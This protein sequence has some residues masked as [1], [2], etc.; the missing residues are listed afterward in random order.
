MTYVEELNKLPGYW[1]KIIKKLE[2]IQLKLTKAKWSTQFNYVCLQENLLPNYTRMRHHDPALASSRDTMN[3]RKS[4]VQRELRIKRETAL[5]IERE[6][7][8]QLTYINNSDIN[9]GNALRE[10]K[11]KMDNFNNV[12]KAKT[13]KKLNQLYNGQIFL[14]E[15]TNCYVNLSQYELT[16]NE[17]EFLNLGINFH[18]QPKYDRLTKKTELELLYNNLVNLGNKN[19]I[20]I[21]QDLQEQL[22]SEGTKHRNRYNR[23]QLPTHLKDAAKK[24]R[25]NKDIIIRKADKS[26]IYVILDRDD[27]F[28]KLNS[29]LSDTTKFKVINKD[30]TNELKVKANKLIDSLNSVQDDIKIDKIVGDFDPGYA[31][32]N[33]KIHKHGNPLR[34]II[35]QCP[36]PTYQLAKTINKII[37]PYIPNKFS[38]K[39]PSDFI[40]ILHSTTTNGII[41][42]L[43]VDS[44]FTNVPIDPTIDIIIKYVY[45]HPILPPPK[46]PQNI[47]R[48]FL[49]ICTK[50][51]PF[52]SPTGTLY[53][54]IEGV[55][56]GSPLGPT[57]AGFYMGDLEYNVFNNY[58]TKPNIYV[59][60]V[61]DIFLQI[62]NSDQLTDIKDI[63]QQ[64]SVLTFTYELHVNN[65]LPFLDISVTSTNTGFKTSIHYK[66]TD[67]GRC[68][69]AQG[70]CPDKY[71]LSVINN[72]IHRAYK[73]S[74]TWESFHNEIIHIK[75]TLINNNYSNSMVDNEISRYLNNKFS[76]PNHTDHNS[77]PVYY[78]SQMHSNYKIDEK[79]LKDIVYNNI[80][81]INPTDK[82][83]LIIYYNNRKASNLVLKNNLAPPKT[84]L[85][86]TNLVYAFICPL[87]HPKVSV[88]IGYTKTRLLRRLKSHLQK[89]SIKEHFRLSHN[90]ELTND[91]VCNNT[92]IIAKDSDKYRLT[93]KEA[94]LI[95]Q[96]GPLINKQFDNFSNTLKLFKNNTSIEPTI[97]SFIHTNTPPIRNDCTHPPRSPSP[98]QDLNISNNESYLNDHITNTHSISPNINNRIHSLLQNSRNN[99]N[100]S[101]QP[102]LRMRSP[103]LLRPRRQRLSYTSQVS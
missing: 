86:N 60:Y 50:E 92:H 44:L 66:P 46:I 28:N 87:T 99:I 53:L 88:Y 32:G 96:H 103:H 56:M 45:H 52:R 84:S 102:S 91:I 95:S 97:P 78:K 43:D 72:F 58:Y 81:C 42:S 18:L 39:S 2:N 57:F 36:T 47:M 59:R 15:E 6:E 40:D 63:F 13:L 11:I 98:T 33:V 54:Q 20:T 14:K 80:K 62:N 27:Y 64:K 74:Q 38:I 17:K 89:G 41:A 8:D 21:N 82:L 22:A 9:C 34:P 69:N 5:R 1:K 71:K 94:L 16:E 79:I 48:G 30:P 77:I 70:N 83:N 61:D 25:D 75:Q 101:T 67:H 68:L 24:L 3:Y 4:I 85:Q 51:S 37:S 65:K 76:P 31:Y 100:S 29:I 73:Y 12:L 23:N 93:V 10:L 49:S 55:A 19:K 90:T 26:S 35:S 7:V